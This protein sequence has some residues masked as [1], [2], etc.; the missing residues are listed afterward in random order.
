M[1]DAATYSA[2]YFA[3]GSERSDSL[4]TA[5][6]MKSCA[7]KATTDHDI[8]YL[9]NLRWASNGFDFSE[10]VLQDVAFE[11][12]VLHRREPLV[13]HPFSSESGELYQLEIHELE[14]SI[15]AYSREELVDALQDFFIVLWNEYALED[16]ANLTV[17]ARELKNLLLSDF[18]VVEQCV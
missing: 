14:I 12:G 11:Q 5:L 15:T 13:L 9:G 16:D 17:N 2:R 1:T 10:I 18:C 7:D 8:P 4:I 3:T 6:I